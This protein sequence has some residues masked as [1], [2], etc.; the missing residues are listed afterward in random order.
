VQQTEK[1]P[2]ERERRPEER[3]AG[4]PRRLAVPTAVPTTAG[5]RDLFDANARHYDRVNRVITFGRDAH[6]RRWA[7]RQVLVGAAA[8]QA[9]AGRRS[10]VAGARPMGAGA[11]RAPRKVL[12]ACAGTGLAGLEAARLGAQVTLADLSD[13]MLGVARKRAAARGLNVDARVVDLTAALPPFPPES[14]DAALLAFGLRY[15][16]DP[17]GAVNRIA[18]MLRPGGEFVVLES[19]VPPQGLAHRVAESYFMRVAPVVATALAGH[20]AL[21][22]LLTATTRATGS[23][24]GVLDILHSAGLD[25]TERRDFAFGLV[26]GIVARKP[27]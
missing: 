6:W 24:A 18:A 16:R 22:R 26:V 4:V 8:E 19:V 14:F 21:Y 17:L 25:V 2:E 20:V 12:D 7:A 5:V 1:Q 15:F 27:S 10:T 9:K 13:G 3:P 23:A 11:A